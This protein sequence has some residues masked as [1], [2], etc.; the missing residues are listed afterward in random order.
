MSALASIE[1]DA[2][3]SA[4]ASPKIAIYLQD[5]VD[6]GAERMMLNLAGGMADAG[7][8]VDLVLVRA[9]GPFMSMIPDNVRLVDLGGRRTM[10][11]IPALARYLR[12]ERPAAV[13]SALIHVNVA[14]VMA[15]YLSGHGSRVVVSE[16]STISQEATE[17]S[18][19]TIHAAYRLVPWVYPR[20]DGIIAVSRGAAEDL[21]RYCRLPDERIAVINNPVV[22][23]SL[24]RQAAEP[25]DHSWFAPGAPPVILSVGRL[26]PEKEFDTVIRAVAELAPRRLVRL[27]ILGEGTERPALEALIGEL[28]LGDRVLLPGFDANPYAYMARAAVLVLSSRWEGSP[29]VLV[30]AMAC[31]TPVVATDCRSGP[32]ELLDDGRLGPLVPVG[33]HVAMAA[34]IDRTLDAPVASDELKRRAAMFSVEAAARAYLRV[35]LGDDWGNRQA[36]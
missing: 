5:L 23:P 12:R 22:G 27:M 7:V 18:A 21:A 26:S 32:A 14:A 30:E 31:G 13:L 36:T 1:P 20:A 35:L 8:A 28:G 17:I 6:G 16:R 15:A 4:A 9:S 24:A 2:A 29:N 33:D 3:S 19:F 34:A 25:L 11:S 10:L